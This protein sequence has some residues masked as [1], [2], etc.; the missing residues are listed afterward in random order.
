MEELNKYNFSNQDFDSFYREKIIRLDLERER[1]GLLFNSVFSK[2][3]FV[4]FTIVNC[5]LGLTCIISA[6]CLLYYKLS[7]TIEDYINKRN[8]REIQRE[9]EIQHEHE[10]QRERSRSRPISYI[11]VAEHLNSNEE[12]RFPSILPQCGS[13]YDGSDDTSENNSRICQSGIPVDN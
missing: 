6:S 12:L 1:N 13:L 2:S 8:E 5:A 4:F 3:D 10:I 11:Q 7:K 9:H